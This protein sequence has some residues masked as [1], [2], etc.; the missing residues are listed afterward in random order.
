MARHSALTRILS[1]LLILTLA[2]FLSFPASLMVNV[3]LASAATYTVTNTDDAGAGSFRQ[4]ITDA[5]GSAGTDAIVFDGSLSGSI[6]LASDLPVISEAVTIDGTTAANGQGGADIALGGTGR[7]YCLKFDAGTGNVVK[8]IGCVGPTDGLIVTTNVTGITIGGTGERELNEWNAASDNGIEIVGADNVT[9]L[10]STIGLATGNSGDGIDVSGT[11]SNITIGG[12]AS[13]SRN[14]IVKNAGNG[15]NLNDVTTVTIQDNWIGTNTGSDDLVNSLA[16]ITAGSTVSGLTIGGTVAN[17]GNVI[18]GNNNDGIKLANSGSVTIQGNKIGLNND[19]T[20]DLGNSNSGILI[21]TSGSNTIGGT[22]SSARNYISGNGG[23]GI[24]IAPPVGTA[25]D[26]VIKFNYIGTN[27]TGLGAIANDGAGIL[28]L[29]GTATGTIIGGSSEGNIISGNGQSGINIGSTA[30]TGT[31]IKGNSIGLGDDE[32]GIGNGAHGIVTVADNTTIG[33]TNVN[34]S[35]NFISSNTLGGIYLNGADSAT[36]VN[37]YIGLAEN[38]TTTR[39]NVEN[40]ILIDST[41]TSNTIGGTATGAANL[42]SA[43]TGKACIQMSANAGNFNQFRR[44]NCLSYP[45]TSNNILLSGG[46]ESIAV[47]LITSATTS[48]ISGTSVANGT[49]EISVNGSYA[50]TSTADGSGDWYKHMAIAT[51]G[52]TSATVTNGSNSTSATSVSVVATTDSTAPTAPTIS[53]PSNNSYVGATTVNLTGTK[54]AYTNILVGGVEQVAND[55]STTWTANSV[56]LTEGANTLS[57]TSQDLSSN[58]SSA[59][60]VTVNR[61]TATPTAPTLSYSSSSTTPATITGSGTEASAD[62]LVNTVDSGVNVDSLGNFSVEV[63]MGSGSNSISITIRDAALNTSSASVATIT[64]TGGVAGFSGTGGGGGGSSSGIGS[65][66]SEPTVGGEEEDSGNGSMSGES[67]PEPESEPEETDSTSE[68]STDE[69]DEEDASESTPTPEVISEPE[70]APVY[71]PIKSFIQEAQNIILPIKQ[72]DLRADLPPAPLAP[73]KFNAALIEGGALGSQNDLGVP[74]MLIEIKLGGVEPIANQDT[75]GDG[76]Y[77]YEEVLYGGNPEVKDTD[78]DGFSDLDEVYFQG[79]NPDSFDTDKDGRPD[80]TDVEP[81]IYNAPELKPQEVTD[82]IADNQITTSLGQTDS[83]EDGI[84]DLHE[85]ILYTDPQDD[86]SDAD[87]ISDGDEVLHLGTDPNTTTLAS[88][89]GVMR[90]VNTAPEEKVEEGKQ[91]YMGNAMP[92]EVIQINEIDEDGNLILLGE[93]LADD[94]GRF[95]IYTDEELEAGSHNL[96]LTSGEDEIKDICSTF[97]V[98]V[99]AVADRPEFVNLGLADGTTIVEKQPTLSLKIPADHMLVVTWQSSIYSQTLIA[100]ASDET[101]EIRPPEELEL[102]EHS[103]TWY[104]VDL[105]TNQKSSPTQ[106][107]F[108]VSTTA[109]VSG[110]AAGSN[111]LVIALGSLTVLASLTALALFFRSRRMNA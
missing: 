1:H 99:V 35:R 26:N 20:A 72:K 50:A 84:S 5:N 86:D 39:T 48:Y 68:T 29:S 24:K 23:D 77:D 108:N 36:V 57:V 7:T 55:S 96:I 44:N 53:S 109:F 25:N 42:I 103:V 111:W 49:V 45:A 106:V 98:D 30:A 70:P 31:I 41:A 56:A 11:A 38:G 21:E 94:E 12:T 27:Q 67:E 90:V 10:N 14:I 100:D 93:A 71:V 37:N 102:G 80:I 75:D 22:T 32:S 15:I 2:G 19:G 54:D 51:S 105:E 66:S 78:G 92:N 17:S 13:G 58:T 95:A 28:I 83:D 8:G 87:G 16:G 101:V 60:T 73:I 110:E 4:A 59:A 40:G 34:G 88:A 76:L 79:T 63:S 18:S 6:G 46:N 43:V 97:S 89:A 9:I 52:N 69:T 47:P 104:A 61:D 65:I 107:N 3:P 85:M 82:Y 62:V 74:Q 81:L 33:E 64:N 91:F